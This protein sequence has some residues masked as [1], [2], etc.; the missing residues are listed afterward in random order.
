M[1]MTTHIFLSLKDEFKWLG[2]INSP[3]LGVGVRLRRFRAICEKAFPG[4]W[5][6]GSKSSAVVK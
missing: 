5:L 6:G 2:A 3:L 4:R 1:I